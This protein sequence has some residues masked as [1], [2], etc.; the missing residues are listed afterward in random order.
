MGSNFRSLETGPLRDFLFAQCFAIDNA[1]FS[2]FFNDDRNH[3]LYRVYEKYGTRLLAANER[4]FRR[5]AQVYALVLLASMPRQGQAD[6]ESALRLNILRCICFVYDRAAPSQTWSGLV[7]EPDNAAID[8]TFCSDIADI[9]QIDPLANNSFR[10]DWLSLIP[11]IVCGTKSLTS[12]SDWPKTALYMIESI[13]YG[14]T[15]R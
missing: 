10:N 1:L 13:D 9:L 12:K 5:L 11:S 14:G 8:A 6:S 3:V 2:V 4:D 15:R 7:L